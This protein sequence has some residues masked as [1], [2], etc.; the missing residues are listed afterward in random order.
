MTEGEQKRD[1]LRLPM[2]VEEAVSDLLQ[3]NNPRKNARRPLNNLV[4]KI[5]DTA[6][7]EAAALNRG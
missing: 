1:R 2:K 7:R 3:G 6:K 5:I 4:E